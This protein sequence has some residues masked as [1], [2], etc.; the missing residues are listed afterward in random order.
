M[1]SEFIPEQP[2]TGHAGN[3][4]EF[5]NESTKD[6]MPFYL[7]LLRSQGEMFA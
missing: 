3:I 7:E 6:Y 4:I 2:I 5:N 1:G